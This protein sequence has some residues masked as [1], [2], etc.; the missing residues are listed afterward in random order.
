MAADEDDPAIRPPG[1]VEGEGATTEEGA[2]LLSPPPDVHATA[3]DE[4]TGEELDLPLDPPR[5]DLR[6][7]A[8]S[9]MEST[10]PTRVDLEGRGGRRRRGRPP[11]RRPSVD[12][13]KGGALGGGGH[14]GWLKVGWAGRVGG[15]KKM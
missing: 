4:E 7:A 9:S 3:E 15:N 14:G 12:G 2:A 10:R 5:L 6:L 11:P 13:V 1:H 8:W